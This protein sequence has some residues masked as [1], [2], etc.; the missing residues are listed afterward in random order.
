MLPKDIYFYWGNDKMTYLRYM[1]FLSFRFY[2]PDWNMYLIMRRNKNQ[3]NAHKKDLGWWEY[4]DFMS[5]DGTE[6]YNKKIRGLNINIL[7]LEDE[8]PEIAAMNITDIHVSDIL[9][10]KILS[11]KGG[12]VCD[13]DIIFTKEFPY[14]KYKDVEFG[15]V[16]F[17][18][19][20]KDNYMPVSFM[21]GQPNEIFRKIYNHAIKVVDRKIYE[22]A[23]T[24]AV[25]N[26]VG[27][28]SAIAKHFPKINVVK[29]PS[30][31]VFPF[32]EDVHF[33]DIKRLTFESRE[34]LPNE[35]IGIHWYA[36]GSQD[37]N[38]QINGS[39]FKNYG[40]VGE[41][42]GMI[43][44]FDTRVRPSIFNCV[45]TALDMLKF[46][47]DA[48]LWNAG[49]N[50]FDYIIV[51][52]LAS[53]EV[54]DYLNKIS[55]RNS[56]IH[57]VEYNTNNRVG[58]VPNLRSMMNKGFDF[59]YSLNDYCG[60]V[61]TDMFFG[62]DWLLNL[63]KYAKPNEIVNS[64]HITPITGPHVVTANLGIPEYGKFNAKKF[65]EL[66]IKLF[67]DRLEGEDKRGGWMATNTMPYLIHKKFWQKAGPWELT[68][69]DRQTPDRR[70][71]QRCKDAGAF[72][73]MSHGSI[74]YHHEAVER[75]GKRPPGS[76]HMSNE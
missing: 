36:G 29:L 33:K 61:N 40:T 19:W 67:D 63:V 47:T 71:F 54:L 20:P 9:A 8:H 32:S 76:E 30:K 49:T 7:Y 62:K 66:Y 52:W 56:N 72:F 65:D 68:I 10:W 28:F 73:T 39:N 46:S 57:I 43:I 59:G 58:Y 13:T 2:N 21:I 18:K 75:R 37:I 35:T 22:S 14:E 50:D 69:T 51:H 45:S 15:A 24:P 6:D 74:V 34:K 26:S 44:N 60:L 3:S 17:S 1:T 42:I 25:E 11:Y 70:F 16:C 4:Q 41:A 5:D 64:V 55:S 53:K 27:K 48:I 31:I 12:I 23:G 38:K